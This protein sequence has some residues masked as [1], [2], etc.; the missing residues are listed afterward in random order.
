MEPAGKSKK[1]KRGTRDDSEGGGG[2]EVFA[3]AVVDTVGGRDHFVQV[4]QGPPTEVVGGV[5][6]NHEGVLVTGHF[7]PT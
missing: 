4:H 5:N 2:A 7:T 3:V 1:R 6:L